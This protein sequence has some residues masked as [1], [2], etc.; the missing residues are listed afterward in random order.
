MVLKLKKEK[1]KGLEVNKAKT[2]IIG[3][4]AVKIR[5]G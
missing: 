4:M 2:G 1:G 3:K 5:D